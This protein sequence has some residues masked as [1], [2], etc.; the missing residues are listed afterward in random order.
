MRAAR[1]RILATATRRALRRWAVALAR[2]GAGEEREQR[3]HSDSRDRHLREGVRGRVRRSMGDQCLLSAAWRWQLPRRL[4]TPSGTS[5]SSGAVMVG[6]NL[7][8]PHQHRQRQRH[9]RRATSLA[10]RRVLELMSI[11]LHVVRRLSRTEVHPIQAH[12]SARSFP[13]AM[14]STAMSLSAPTRS[15]AVNWSRFALVG[16]GT[17]LAAVAA[18]VLAYFIASTVVAYNAEFLPL[19]SVGGAII[20]TLAPAIVAVLLYAALLRFTRH[21]ARIFTITSAIVFIISLI[22]AFTYIPTVPGA[23]NAQTATLVLMHA[24]AASVIVA[25]L[26]SI[27]RT[28]WE[29]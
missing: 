3:D 10:C 28:S 24:V 15:S 21:P 4:V 13:K 2:R 11:W 17:V 25:F 12:A 27:R 14:S 16:P 26:T 9:R 22:P 8:F 6:T 19:A 7:A 1:A 23:T 5:Q 20:M 29:S 18:N